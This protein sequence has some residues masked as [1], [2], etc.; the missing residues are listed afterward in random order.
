MMQSVAE[1]LAILKQLVL[2]HCSEGN[3]QTA[4]P[5]LSFYHSTVTTGLMQAIYEPCICIVLQGA[6]T[7]M[8]GTS[9]LVYDSAHY[10]IVA[11]D[12]PLTC[13]VTTA[14]TAEPYIGVRIKL[15]LDILQSIILETA[16]AAPPARPCPSLSLGKVTPE[17]L[18]PL[19]RLTNL[20]SQP[21][22]ARF[23]APLV[24]REILYRLLQGADAEMVRQLALSG[25]RFFKVSKAIDWIRRSYREPFSVET[26]AA[27]ANMSPSSFHHH[28]KA[29]TSMSPLQY[30][31]QMRLHEARRLILME[32]MDAAKAGFEV[33]YDSPSQF[34]R[35][36]KR[37]FGAPPLRETTL[38][39]KTSGLEYSG[40]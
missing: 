10:L 31:K 3:V 9:T 18:D 22:D 8:L 6:K 4:L 36:Y 2:P 11:V 24:E 29:V 23:L 34:S 15:Q 21:Q 28:F 12:L 17:L 30:Q 38:F 13:S 1:S 20:L 35:E 16:Q 19:I 7:A 27:A 14:S 25:T 32:Q 5:C 37:V 39:R 26:A 40:L 33:G